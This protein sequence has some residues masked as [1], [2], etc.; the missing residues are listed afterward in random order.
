[1]GKPYKSELEALADTY[2][3]AMGLPIDPLTTAVARAAGFP[4]LA[5]GSGGSFTAA[6]FAST[7]HQNHT[8]F[9]SKALTPLEFVSSRFSP[10][11]T[12]VLVLSANG[13]NVD[14]V[15]CFKNA[16]LREPA[17][18]LVLCL[19]EG[20]LLSRAA[21]D[22]GFV[23]LIEASA[24]TRQDGFLATNS[25]LALVVLLSRA[26]AQAF[27]AKHGLP[28]TLSQLFSLGTDTV[29]WR[30]HLRHLCEPLWQKDTLL[31]LFSPALQAAA[32]DL[33]SKFSEAALGTTQIADFRNFAHGRH[34]WLA[35]RAES[36]AVLALVADKDSELA[37][38]TLALLPKA[39]PIA[40]L[41]IPA[42]TVAATSIAAI[43]A[44]LHIVGCAGEA[45][46]L[47]PGRPGVPEFG[48]R[49][50][51]L[52]ASKSSVA[53]KFHRYT[54]E[55]VAIARKLG[56]DVMT[57]SEQ[58]KADLVSWRHGFR[59]YVRSFDRIGFRGIVLDYD[60]TLCEARERFTG[61]GDE[62]AG[63][64]TD[65]V[66]HGIA[67]GV[68]TGR[69]KSVRRDLQAKIPKKLWGQILIGYYNASLIGRLGDAGVPGANVSP[70][71]LIKSLASAVEVHPLL[72]SMTTGEARH[73]Q[74]SLQP[75]IAGATLRIWKIA[76]Q[77]IQS[78]PGVRAVI[79]SH[80]VDLLEPGVSKRQLVEQLQKC[81]T[82]EEPILT[83]GDKGAWPGNDFELLSL[84]HSLS[85]D[86]V[87]AD[88]NSC[89][90][91]APLGHRGS[92]A[93]LDYLSALHITKA[94][95]RLN[96]A[97]FGGRLPTEV[98]L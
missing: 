82:G 78:F 33:E 45:R 53:A 40:T 13:N 61:L 60:G 44:A 9:P 73:N 15:G 88:P 27:F 81:I 35:K 10:R 75:K 34:N 90:N 48:R 77:M 86:E 20:S 54:T 21:A 5:V 39:I 29:G 69:G 84:P 37:T 18:C 98:D 71:P 96:C 59:T 14:I 31:V 19:R 11:E 25:L 1:M 41:E 43:V 72:G 94:R 7:L 57:L 68:A 24:P 2:L 70:S 85:V 49:I 30:E 16:T 36:T 87:S 51:N 32:L 28:D 80:S 67:I 4:L 97:R 3:W 22:F 92:Q 74:L 38:K 17:R 56:R 8:G 47:D 66:R 76:Q 93:A 95:V 55:D 79:S 89:W 58:P 42:R 6:Y 64:L 65:L 12:A 52:R 83:V 63:I 62:I 46:R 23:D 91:L 50:Y 26:Y